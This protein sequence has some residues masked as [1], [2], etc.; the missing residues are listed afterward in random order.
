MTIK[1]N[2]K[3][4]IGV[5]RVD[6]ERSEKLKQSAYGLSWK[7]QIWKLKVPINVERIKSSN[8]YWTNEPRTTTIK[9][10]SFFEGH[11]PPSTF[12]APLSCQAPPFFEI[13]PTS[14]SWI[15]SPFSKTF[16]VTP[17]CKPYFLKALYSS[18]PTYMWKK[19]NWL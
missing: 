12:Y 14:L 11:N 6:L 4:R 1:K 17:L 13:F 2:W 3:Y 19:I 5:N 8:S 15:K 16:F 9:I 7:S 10:P 18:Q